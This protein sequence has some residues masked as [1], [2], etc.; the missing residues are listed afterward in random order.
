MDD[1]LIEHL[2]ISTLSGV[3]FILIGRW[4]NGHVRLF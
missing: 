4:N 2:R 3:L 1:R